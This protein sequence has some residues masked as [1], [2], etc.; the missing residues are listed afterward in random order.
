[1]NY[2]RTISAVAA[3]LAV[4][5][6]AAPNLPSEADARTLYGSSSTRCF[7]D[8]SCTY[9]TYLTIDKQQNPLRN[10]WSIVENLV[11]QHV[12]PDAMIDY[13]VVLRREPLR[14]KSVGVIA[15]V[16]DSHFTAI[17]SRA[18]YNAHYRSRGYV[19]K[20]A[21]YGS[22]CRVGGLCEKGN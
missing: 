7:E 8:G 5:A 6:V 16:E 17:F 19:T 10:S 2:K 3:T 4:A 1:V 22:Y 13:N 18:G 9:R 14:I 21:I 15:G 11:A 20:V 12:G